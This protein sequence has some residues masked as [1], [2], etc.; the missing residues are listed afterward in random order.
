[1]LKK[2]IENEK[3][4]IRDLMKT[5][6]ANVIKNKIPR[7]EEIKIWTAF[8]NKLQMEDVKNLNHSIN[9]FNLLVPLLN[10]QMVQFSIERESE[11]ILKKYLSN[12]TNQINDSI[13]KIDV[14]VKENADVT[15]NGFLK[16]I[17]KK[18]FG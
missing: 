4:K 10:S 18:F 15:N 12:L 5:Q 17:M 8:L 11:I 6:A 14:K 16:S 13:E 2:E 1:M 7:R 3:A 9:R